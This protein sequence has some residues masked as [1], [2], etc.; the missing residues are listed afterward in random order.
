MCQAT[1]SLSRQPRIYF[2]LW[3]NFKWSEKTTL[4]QTS[5]VRTAA[6]KSKMCVSIVGRF[7]RF[8]IALKLW[9]EKVPRPL[10]ERQFFG[11]GLELPRSRFSQSTIWRNILHCTHIYIASEFWLSNCHK[12]WFACPSR[13]TRH[14]DK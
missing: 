4:C 7:P 1:L 5:P 9:W 12:S 14:N 8:Y 2:P 6:T 3:I 10:R 11:S 13:K